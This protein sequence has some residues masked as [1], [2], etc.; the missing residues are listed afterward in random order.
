[1]ADATPRMPR[2]RFLRRTLG[3]VGVA[4]V[5]GLTG[6]AVDA[7]PAMGANASGARLA[8]MRR[9]P[10][11]VNGR[12][13][14][15]LSVKVQ[16][17]PDLFVDQVRRADVGR[18]RV[19]VPYAAVSRSEAALPAAVDGAAVRWLGHATLLVEIGGRRILV[20][21]LFADRAGPGRLLGPSRFFPP[22]LALADLPPIDAVVITHD[23]YDH[24]SAPTIR[25]LA[26]RVPRFVVPLGVG[27]HLE[28]WGVAPGRIAELDWWETADVGG[29]ALTATPARHF[30]GRGLRNRDGT[31]WCGYALV[32]P[33]ARLYLSGDSGY[34]P[35]FG[36]IGARLGPF[37]LACVE[38]GAYDRR[39]PDVH[40]GPE[41]AVQA[42]QDVRAAT[43]LPLHWAT[44]NLA[45]HGWTE[46][47]ERVLVAAEAAGA[48]L[49]LPRPGAR[50]ALGAL[51]PPAQWWPDV[52]WQTADE[53]PIVS[54][55][56]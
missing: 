27:A 50:I 40:M 9:S 28:R 51:P 36:E 52:A 33:S 53:A 37:D 22:P 41:Q 54:S 19:P 29:V 44:F 20:D 43:M 55:A 26:A 1:M 45:F 14:T 25:A 49:T 8:R 10:H 21:P 47:G 24:L 11:Y 38:I 7:V 3:I 34:G 17:D 48:A 23:H 56:V 12:F 42:A 5:A 18:P 32:T 35:H 6:V 46:P 2:R 31:L 30:S 16:V 39:W 13:R 4:A 15:P